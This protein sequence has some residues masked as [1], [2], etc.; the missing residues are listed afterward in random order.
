MQ[1]TIQMNSIKP[2]P[3][4]NAEKICGGNL[5]KFK[6]SLKFISMIIPPNKKIILL[7]DT[8]SIIS[9]SYLLENVFAFVKMLWYILF[10]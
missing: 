7:N 4:A 9:I 8:K 10:K 3:I 1:K 2:D 6:K 5:K